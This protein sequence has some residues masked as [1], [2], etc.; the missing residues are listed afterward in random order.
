L[1]SVIEHNPYFT[2]EN[3]VALATTATIGFE[4]PIVGIKSL[5]YRVHFKL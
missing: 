5:L 1:S 4:K 2:I 3:V